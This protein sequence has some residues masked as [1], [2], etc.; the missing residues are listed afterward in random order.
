MS[1]SAGPPD[2]R[3]LGELFSEMSN[4]VSELFRKEVELAKVELKQEAQRAGKAGGLLGGA[5]VAAYLALLF[6]SLA[7]ALALAA[8]MP[9][10][11]A[12]LLVGVL[13]AIGAAVLAKQGRARLKQ[14]NVVPDQTV[15]TLK[16]D[17]QW[18][19]TQVK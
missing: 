8:L 9:G 12:F 19:R 18:A 4:E 1:A 2:D 6:V 13:Y 3:S 7:I 11:L 10:W 15:Q 16:E 17:A 5:A 14:V